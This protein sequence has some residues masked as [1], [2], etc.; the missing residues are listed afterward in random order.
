M[1]YQNSSGTLLGPMVEELPMV[2]VLVDD[3]REGDPIMLVIERCCQYPVLDHT[4]VLIGRDPGIQH[5]IRD[6]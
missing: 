5:E 1:K 2:L 6:G 4:F 3:T